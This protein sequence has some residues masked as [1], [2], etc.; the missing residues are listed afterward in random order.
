MTAVPISHPRKVGAGGR[1]EVSRRFLVRDKWGF[2]ANFLWG[3]GAFP[4]SRD[5]DPEFL[6]RAGVR[7]GTTRLLKKVGLLPLLDLF[8]PKRLGRTDVERDFFNKARQQ[9]PW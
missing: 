3:G 1:W 5:F 9:W 7:D 4:S 2:D 8:P 6:A